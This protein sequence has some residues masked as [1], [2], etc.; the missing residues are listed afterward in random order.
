MFVRESLNNLG[1]IRIE[2]S[3]TLNNFGIKETKLRDNRDEENIIDLQIT[4]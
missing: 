1:L 2:H 4:N 3:R